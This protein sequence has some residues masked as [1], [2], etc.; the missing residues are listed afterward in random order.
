MASRPVRRANFLGSYLAREIV[1]SQT[2]AGSIGG[3]IGDSFASQE[4]TAFA[5]GRAANDHEIRVA[6]ELAA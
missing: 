3:G 6:L 1:A 5:P 4:A 2:L